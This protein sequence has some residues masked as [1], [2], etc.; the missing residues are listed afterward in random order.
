MTRWSKPKLSHAHASEIT[1]AAGG[2]PVMLFDGVCNLCS[3]WVQFAIARDP[4]ARL[5]FAAVQSPL[6]QA[7]L[8]RQGL[9]SDVYESFYFVEDG[10]VYEKSTGWFRMV[11]HLRWPWPWFRA[12]AILPRGLRDFLYDRI[13]RN[14]YRWFGRRD[15][16]LVPTPEIAARFIG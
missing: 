12:L 9:P 6:G 11:R 4:Q 5:R 3:A 1:A 13:A 7:F 10:I 2:A 15:A 16:C 8:E 14:R